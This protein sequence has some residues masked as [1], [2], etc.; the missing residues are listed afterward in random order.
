MPRIF[1]AGII[2]ASLA[3]P[4]LATGPQPE[5]PG[6]Q[7]QITSQPAQNT[8]QEKSPPGGRVRTLPDYNIQKE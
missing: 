3:G 8:A 2:M 5:S 1:V 7:G 4:A 6:Q